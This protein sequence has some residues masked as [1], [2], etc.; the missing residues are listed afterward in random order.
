MK[1]LLNFMLLIIA[2][3]IVAPTPIQ[4]QKKK[5]EKEFVWEMPELTKNDEFDKYLLTCDT[6][7]TRIREYCDNIVFYQVK[8]IQE[9]DEEGNVI[10]DENGSPKT[11]FAVVDSA[12]HIRGASEAIVQYAD[13]ILAG[14]N[15]LLDMANI[16]LLTTSATTELPS[17]GLK[18]VS[19]AK[20]LKAGPKLVQY[21][22]Q[23]IRD[24]L[25]NCKAQAQ[26]IRKYK[27]SFTESGELIDPKADVS[28]LEGLDLNDLPVI[29]KPSKELA[30]ELEKAKQENANAKELDE[31]EFEGLM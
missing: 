26:T 1:S 5:K 31:D 8:Q 11:I 23:E 3:A 4:A 15:L 18:S 16:A 6:L 17:L 10:M 13:V 12:N 20:Y 2:V 28:N 9:T 25:A 19:Y 27:N 22:G 7:N 29:T 30:E 14:T 24:I 21:G